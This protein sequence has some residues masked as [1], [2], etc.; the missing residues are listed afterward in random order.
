[1]RHHALD[2]QPCPGSLSCHL[3]GMWNL[4]AQRA[5]WAVPARR[6]GAWGR[7]ART[8]PLFW[9]RPLWAAAT[10]TLRVGFRHFDSTRWAL[11]ALARWR[12]PP[13]PEPPQHSRPHGLLSHCPQL[14]LTGRVP[15]AS[16]LKI[17]PRMACGKAAPGYFSGFVLPWGP[18]ELPGP[19]GGPAMRCPGP[20]RSPLGL[21]CPVQSPQRWTSGAASL[22][23]GQQSL[24]VMKPSLHSQET[25][26]DRGSKLPE[27]TVRVC[28]GDPGQP[29]L[30]GRP[31]P[32][33]RNPR[34]I[35]G[36]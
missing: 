15:Q 21:S 14:F 10:E 25:G 4:R 28:H 30:G 29:A 16:G 11:S 32:A 1:M 20:A 34:G 2:S 24:G 3:L 22:Q 5:Q 27:A 23:G 35:W 26:S 36:L 8:A 6:P 31:D 9:S 13:R 12:P 33:P 17:P 18:C 7:S 19:G